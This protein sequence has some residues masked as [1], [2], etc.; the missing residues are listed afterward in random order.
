MAKTNVAK[1]NSGKTTLAKSVDLSEDLELEDDSIALDTLLEPE[2][3]L[4][5]GE[6]ADDGAEADAV[7]EEAAADSLEPV[8]SAPTQDAAVE[9]AQDV[10]DLINALKSL[11]TAVEKLQK[12]RQDVGDIKPLIVR[13]L[14]GDVMAGEELEQLK[15]GVAG[16]FR[17]T[18]AYS[19]HQAALLKAQPARSL[20]DDVLK[21]RTV[22]D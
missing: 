9:T 7:G 16:L 12:V 5:D 8:T 18:R 22:S 1:A 11:L 13:M 19:D 2:D 6:A 14:D 4:D 21:V 15:T 3:A 10:D 17:L 20:L